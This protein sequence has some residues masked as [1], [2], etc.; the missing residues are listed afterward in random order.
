MS[1]SIYLLLSF[2]PGDHLFVGD[3]HYRVAAT[4]LLAD[5][6]RAVDLGPEDVTLLPGVTVAHGTFPRTGQLALRCPIR[7]ARL[8]RS[9]TKTLID[10]F[11]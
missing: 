10:D 9:L 11:P 1:R 7:S 2:S 8:A 3:Q 4:Y 6:G 5:D